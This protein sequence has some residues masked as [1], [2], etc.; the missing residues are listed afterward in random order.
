M[1]H[2]VVIAPRDKKPKLALLMVVSVFVIF[3]AFLLLGI[4]L[5]ANVVTVEEYMT[6][7]VVAILSFIVC[8]FCLPVAIF[9]LIN[10]I[11]NAKMKDKACV[12]YDSLNDN[13]ILHSVWGKDIAIR[14]GNI[15]DVSI[16][17]WL[18]SHE[19]KITVKNDDGSL[20]KYNVGFSLYYSKD[21][22]RSEINNYQK[23]AI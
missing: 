7:I 12:E 16:A 9:N 10:Y 21:K 17:T 2:V 14:N 19:V 22:I 13:F 1:E 4:L 5:L 8:C 11:F 20:T 3:F 15:V 6:N 18:Y 23:N